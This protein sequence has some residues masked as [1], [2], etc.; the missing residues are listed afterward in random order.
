MTILL[1]F[2]IGIL[3]YFFYKENKKQRENE[4]WVKRGNEFFDKLEVKKVI[5]VSSPSKGE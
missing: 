1:G 4:E 2:I 5:V 3:G